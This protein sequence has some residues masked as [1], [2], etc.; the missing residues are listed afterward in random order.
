MTLASSAFF[1][2]LLGTSLDGPE[3]AVFRGKCPYFWRDLFRLGE[4]SWPKP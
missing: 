4:S 2:T 3:M 1:Q